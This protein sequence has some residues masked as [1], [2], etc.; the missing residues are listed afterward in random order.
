MLEIL[1]QI[2]SS[3]FFFINGT[4]ANPVTDFL[5]PMFTNDWGLRVGYAVAMILCL[6]FGNVRLRWMVLFSAIVLVLSDQIAA[7]LLKDLIGRLRPCQ[8]FDADSINLLVHC[9]GGKSMPSAHASNAFGQGIFFSIFF[10]KIRPYLLTYAVMVALSRVFVGVHYP[11]D[12]LM[13]AL[14]GTV[15]A[16]AV[17][18]LYKQFEKKVVKTHAVQN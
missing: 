14:I 11:F 13:G 7:N 3:I 8:T 18:F 4:L 12:I 16:I 5:M 2:D 1:Q 9:G 6:I 17:A 15:I 10:K